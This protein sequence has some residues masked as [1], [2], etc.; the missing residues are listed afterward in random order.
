MVAGDKEYGACGSRLKNLHILQ[1]SAI[2]VC[3]HVVVSQ[4]G[5]VSLKL[6]G[7]C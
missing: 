3:Q 2:A 5:K 1:Y 7:S 4:V 6:R